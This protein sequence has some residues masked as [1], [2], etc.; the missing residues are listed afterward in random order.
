ME[1]RLPPPRLLRYF[2]FGLALAGAWAARQRALSAPLFPDTA[3]ARVARALPALLA[4]VEQRVGREVI[5]VMD[6]P[7]YLTAMGW[8]S[9]GSPYFAHTKDQWQAQRRAGTLR[10]IYWVRKGDEAPQL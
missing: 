2:L 1:T 10:R 8:P 9:V 6:P 5:F 3:S 4:S 7:Q